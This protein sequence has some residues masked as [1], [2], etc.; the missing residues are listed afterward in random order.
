M[1]N[2]LQENRLKN[3]A[4]FFKG[5]MSVMPLITAALAPLLTLAKAIP[6][7]E[8][9][10]TSLATFSGLFGFLLVA[11][12]FFARGTFVP[13]MT[14]SLSGAA[15]Q[16]DLKRSKLRAV[17]DW[18]LKDIPRLFITVMPLSLIILSACCYIYYSQRLDIVLDS[19]QSSTVQATTAAKPIQRQDIL[20]TW[21]T[22]QSIPG[23]TM[24]QIL[25]LGIFLC[26]ELA[27]VFM[28]LRE[29]AYGTLHISEQEVL[30]GELGARTQDGQGGPG[31]D[32]MAAK[33]QSGE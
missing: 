23:L 27:F 21:G 17:G 5:Y 7:F 13:L 16:S 9:Q 4:S 11:W 28:A 18:L 1:S 22:N 26:A 24:L 6:V 19:I 3:F 15:A 10:K 8:S 2:E 14:E 33:S 30:T 25:Y 32:S 12:V 29:Y 20:L 31:D